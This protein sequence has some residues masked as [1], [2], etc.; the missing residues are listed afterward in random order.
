MFIFGI[1][2]FAQRAGDL[3]SFEKF[4]A[5]EFLLRNPSD[6][7]RPMVEISPV[8]Q[9]AVSEFTNQ[10]ESTLE[11]FMPPPDLIAEP[12]LTIREQNLPSRMA[13]DGFRVP[14]WKIP[15]WV[16]YYRDQVAIAVRLETPT[17]PED[18]DSQKPESAVDL[19]NQRTEVPVQ[20]FSA[21]T[22]SD[23]SLS[24]LGLRVV[25]SPRDNFKTIGLLSIPQWNTETQWAQ[26]VPEAPQ[27]QSDSP[28]LTF[29]ESSIGLR[30]MDAPA[31]ASAGRLNSFS[32][33]ET[34]LLRSSEDQKPGKFKDY[35]Q[36]NENESQ[37]PKK[38]K[39]QTQLNEDPGAILAKKN[40]E[41]KELSAPPADDRRFAA[42]EQS[43]NLYGGSGARLY[44]PGLKLGK[45]DVRLDLEN[46]FSYSDNYQS[47]PKEALNTSGVKEKVKV[48]SASTIVTTPSVVM[49][50]GE[51]DP[52]ITDALYMA[53]RYTPSLINFV[54]VDRKDI[55]NHDFT[56][57]GGYRFSKLALVLDQ[58]VIP[59]SGGDVEAGNFVS[60]NFYITSVSAEYEISDKTSLELGLSN[61]IRDYQ[62][63]FDSQETRFRGFANYAMS[64]KLRLG[65]GAAYGRAT[66]GG[67]ADQDYQQALMRGVYF[68]TQKS[69]LFAE[70][71]LEQRQL[72]G[73][74]KDQNNLVFRAGGSLA[75][76][77]KTTLSVNASRTEIPSAVSSGTNVDATG[78]N[79]LISQ[80][81]YK[82]KLGLGA[83][84]E[85]VSFIKT[86]KTSRDLASENYYNLSFTT[87]YSIADWWDVGLSYSYRFTD[88]TIGADGVNKDIETNETS[89]SSRIK[90]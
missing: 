45:F 42:V 71:G 63:A 19:L 69:T 12:F 9:S 36:K 14:E 41:A 75:L 53:F 60:R 30:R 82:F 23:S 54:D 46:Q 66:S 29:R 39:D 2:I 64:E 48:E 81:L 83:G 25:D 90:F 56:F 17:L 21:L 26:G 52:E 1:A 80:A 61:N 79:G 7:D 18:Q 65:L 47:S 87:A 55:L 62:G 4:R 24:Q 13:S 67:S 27:A 78:F 77:P 86:S 43:R 33:T 76:F 22:F 16:P 70:T 73:L 85:T 84:Y 37:D 8:D 58:S 49:A 38:D 34:P 44:A 50:S 10:P 31:L 74:S 89:L 59:Y 15:S 72:K 51:R 32:Q 5:P 6:E 88:K 11:T 68:L 40:Q 3:L 57:N 28:L 20:S 35:T